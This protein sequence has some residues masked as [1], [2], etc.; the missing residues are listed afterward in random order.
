[1]KHGAAKSVNTP[2]GRRSTSCWRLGIGGLHRLL[3]LSVRNLR[4]GNRSLDSVNL[5]LTLPLYNT[6]TERDGPQGPR[7]YRANI[8]VNLSLH[9]F[10]TNTHYTVRSLRRLKTG[11]CQQLLGVG[12]LARQFCL[13][14]FRCFLTR[15]T[16][17]RSRPDFP[18]F[19]KQ[20]RARFPS[21][22]SFFSC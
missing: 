2:R 6:P 22:A 8:F 12:L 14:N 10:A 7:V 9:I 13:S 20:K 16:E 4:T 1:M 15:N 11:L 5:I 19:P 18:R 17:I 21:N 3:R